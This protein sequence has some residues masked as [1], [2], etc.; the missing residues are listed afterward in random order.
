MGYISIHCYQL[1]LQLISLEAQWGADQLAEEYRD[2]ELDRNRAL[3]EQEQQSNFG[4]ALVGVSSAHLRSAKSRFEAMLIYTKLEYL[5]G[6]EVT[7][8]E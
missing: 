1:Y 5:I 4:D 6:K 7:L 2:F 8:N 3:Y